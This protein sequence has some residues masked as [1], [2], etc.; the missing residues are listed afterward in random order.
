MTG[1]VSTRSSDSLK[2]QDYK[3]T[4][5]PVGNIA[6]FL[7]NS[8][9]SHLFTRVPVSGDGQYIYDPIYRLIQATGRE[10]PG[11]QPTNLD[12]VRGNV[13]HQNDIQALLRYTEQYEYDE[14]GNITG[15]SH[16]ATGNNWNRDYQYST[17]GNKL[18][19][20]SAPAD[21]PGTYSNTYTYNAHGSMVSMPHITQLSWNYAEQLQSTDLGG[22]G[23]VYYC[24]DSSGNRS[25]KVYEH[26]G[27][28][29]DRIYLGGYEIYRK[30]VGTTLSLERE[31]LHVNDGTKRI[32]LFETKTVD[33]AHPS[34]L[35]QI[36]PRWQMD[37]HLGSSSVE[38]NG[39]GQVISYEEYH[40]FG[41]TSFH[42][43]DTG[44]EISAKRYRYTGK[45]RDDETGLYYFGAR[46]YASWLGRWL[47]CDPSVEDGWNLY[48]YTSNNPVI[49]IDPDGAADV[50]IQ[51]RPQIKPYRPVYRP[52]YKPPLKLGPTGGIS[53]SISNVSRLTA[54]TALAAIGFAIEVDR[55]LI[56]PGLQNE[57]EGGMARQ[58]NDKSNVFNSAEYNAQ[59]S[60]LPSSPFAPAN[61]LK[62]ADY[63]ES[64]INSGQFEKYQVT[65]DEEGN[66]T[67]RLVHSS[68]VESIDI[69]ELKTAKNYGALFE[70]QPPFKNAKFRSIGE[71]VA[72]VKDKDV[73]LLKGVTRN[74]N[75]GVDFANS[76]YLFPVEGEQLNVVRIEYTGSR[77]KDFGAANKAAKISESQKPPELYTWH[78][79][80]D[81]DPQTNTGTMQLIKREVHEAT[82]PHKG[83]IAQYEKHTGKKYK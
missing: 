43:V 56:S 3:Y 9:W 20:T 61:A 37:N 44:A 74:E 63:F 53:P 70:Q 78:H 68:D 16:T 4:F 25:R 7:D 30:T 58:L 26:S 8:A 38:L 35:P 10:H 52:T 55:Y 64:E 71:Y 24:Y 36:R 32:L 33:V 42:T 1:L 23:I 50:N 75:G 11:Q 6:V 59:A 39:S 21:P 18:L 45:E 67:R 28:V 79:L 29:E 80:D 60:S 13:P 65:H 27:I 62:R 69:E 81:Y 22:G 76:P 19:G 48:V 77:R 83:G 17:T 41:S 51:N 47:S 57:L 49:H 40:P 2:L 15:M 66:A 73:D 5:D 72:S 34:G 54:G 82:Y 12:P 14:S 31:T 46:Y